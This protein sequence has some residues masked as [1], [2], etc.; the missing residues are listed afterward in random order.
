MFI[1]LPPCKTGIT[2][3]L[4]IFYLVIM[5]IIWKKLQITIETIYNKIELHQF[6]IKE[7]NNSNLL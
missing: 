4:L 5:Y 6:S 3:F 1:F 2:N 7:K